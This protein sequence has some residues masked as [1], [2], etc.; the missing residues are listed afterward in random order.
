[1]VVAL[2]SALPDLPSCDGG[3]N[4]PAVGGCGQVQNADLGV[5]TF[6]RE[7]RVTVAIEVNLTPVPG[8]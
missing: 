3:E 2:K 4:R 8:R 7:C 6:G 5:A 1:M